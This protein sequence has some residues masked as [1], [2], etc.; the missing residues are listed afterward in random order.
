M[1][2]ISDILSEIKNWKYNQKKT[3]I[4][5]NTNTRST[6]FFFNSFQ[7]LSGSIVYLLFCKFLSYIL[8]SLRKGLLYSSYS[9]ILFCCMDELQFILS[10][11]CWWLYMLFLQAVL[12]NLYL[13]P[14]T[15][16][17]C[18]CRLSFKHEIASPK[19]IFV[20]ECVYIYIHL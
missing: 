19:D 1:L 13:C 20:C 9:C 2:L 16:V 14:F 17:Q 4:K 15:F 6:F 10:V 5:A 12:R 11:P 7:K 18:I 3:D 8:I